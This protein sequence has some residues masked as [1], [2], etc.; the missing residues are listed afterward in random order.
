[1][2]DPI[3]NLLGN[4]SAELNIYSVLLRVSVSVILSALIGWERSIKR[5][6]AG[7]RTFILVCMST[8]LAIMIELYLSAHYDVKMFFLS[9]AAIIAIAIIAANS[10]IFSSRNQMKGLT[11][12]IALWSTGILGLAIGS[13]L[14]TLTL[15]CFVTLMICIIV[16]PAWEVY[17]KNRSNHFEVHLEL[18]EHRFLK[19]FVSTIRKLGLIIDDI[20][21]NPAYAKSGLSVYSIAIS[22]SNDQLRKYK[23]HDEIIKALATLDYVYHIEEITL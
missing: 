14:Y 6:S 23:T 9:G 11:T 4:W 7:L 13:G 16:M 17:L 3:A 21:M 18:T 12:S 8:T 22:I 10:V 15:I 20:E 19:D 1:M 2:N 5:H